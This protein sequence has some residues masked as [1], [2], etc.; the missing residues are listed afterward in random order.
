MAYPVAATVTTMSG[1]YIPEIWSLKTLVKFYTATVFGEISNTDYEGEIQKFGDKVHIRTIPD[2]TMRAYSIGQKLVRQRPNPTKIT[3]NIDKGWYYSMS[4][5][6][7]EMKQADIAYIEK[8]TDD[9]GM[10]MKIKID[11]DVLTNVYADAS[12]YN[13][14]ATAGYKTSSYNMGASGAPYGLDKTNI[15]DFL[16]DMGSVL[17]EID[18]PESGRWAVLPTILCNMLKKSEIKDA[19]L[20]G[21][22][23]GTVRNGRIG[24]IDDLMVYR[25]NQVAQSSDSGGETAHNIMA[26]TRDAITFASQLTEQRTIPN[27]DDFGDLMEGLQ[28]YGYKVIKPE[29]L[30][31]GYVY[32]M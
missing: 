6:A 25:S 30:V 18:A 15:V 9:A 5:N 16:V 4:I 8:W 20:T 23:V 17:T 13:A 1:T 28:V 14:G 29:A 10:Q 7:V 3:L 21:D 12:T 24:R 27:P 11:Y 22:A 19:S 32:K 31:H 2:I 26:G